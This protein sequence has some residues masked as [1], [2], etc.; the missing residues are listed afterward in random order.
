MATVVHYLSVLLMV[1]LWVRP[2]WANLFA[3]VIA[4]NVSFFGHFCWTFAHA[5]AQKIGAFRRFMA[6]ALVGFVVNE[7]LFYLF[8]RWSNLPIEV[9]LFVVLFVVSVLTFIL[10]RWWAFR[11]HTEC[12]PY[13]ACE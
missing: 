7:S 8:L 9:S 2:M 1:A 5:N 6:V 3:F 11:I 10:S 13:D 4:F 12:M